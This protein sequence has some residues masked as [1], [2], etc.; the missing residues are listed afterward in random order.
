M[1]SATIVQRLTGRADIAI[2]FRF[3]SE[4]LGTEEWTSL[5]V[6]TVASA[7]IRRDVPLRQ[8]LQELPI[9]VG[10]VGCHRFWWPSLP[11]AETGEHIFWGYFF[12]TLA[13]G[14]AL[15]T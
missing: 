5:S 9:P 15:P 13:C 6:D 8:P 7:H 14:V 12:L 2:V 4:S 3:I 11:V 1:T 10:R